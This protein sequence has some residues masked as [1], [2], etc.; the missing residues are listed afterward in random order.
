M[1][2]TR[3][4]LVTMGE[5]VEVFSMHV[6]V[7]INLSLCGEFITSG[8]HQRVYSFKCVALERRKSP[9]SRSFFL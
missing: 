4:G 2:N 3:Y 9:C 6:V 8:E 7:D 5:G 1:I